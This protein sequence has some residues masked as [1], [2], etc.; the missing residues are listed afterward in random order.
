MHAETPCAE[1]LVSIIIPV[2]NGSLFMKEAIDSALNQTYANCEVIVVND[3]ST[4]EG[5]TAHIARTYGTRIRYFEKPNGGCGSALNV[6]IANMR[7]AYFSW[8]SHDDVYHRSKI[9]SQMSALWRSD[10]R[11]AIVY[12]GYKLIDG[13]SKSVGRVLPERALGHRVEEP[14]LPLLRGLIHGCCLL[15]PR[16]CFEDCGSFDES[17]L[18]TQ[19][20][21][22]WFK[23]L[24]S[25]PL[26]YDPH[27]YVKSRVHPGQDTQSRNDE[28]NKEAN[29]LW[30][31]FLRSLTEDE[32]R[33]VDG[34]RCAFF[35]NMESF[36]RQT[37]YVEAKAMATTEATV[38][39]SEIKVSVVMPVGHCFAQAREAIL[40]V[41]AQTHS[42]WELLIVGVGASTTA[43]KFIRACGEDPRI[44]YIQQGN[45]G[46]GSARNHGLRLATGKYIAFLD[47][48]SMY[49]PE[50][51][52][53]QLRFMEGNGYEVS[54][55]SYRRVTSDGQQSQVVRSGRQGGEIFPEVIKHCMVATPTAMVSRSLLDD[56]CFPSRLTIG[57]DIC[58]WIKL[59]QQYCWRGI[60]KPLTRVRIGSDFASLTPEKKICG[61]INIASF[62]LEDPTLV[63]HT[64]EVGALLRSAVSLNSRRSEPEAVRNARAER[65]RR[66]RPLWQSIVRE[67]I[68]VGKRVRSLGASSR[69][70]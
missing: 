32:M 21:A 12:S 59:A 42:N 8:L 49:E 47:P 34:S 29:N 35:L 6:G 25:Y 22:L 7:G 2:F 36:L 69:R 61:L 68:R 4:D 14:L 10:K 56:R 66:R 54:H 41:K 50:K 55:T 67:A 64:H 24:R 40:S 58:L 3:G 62:C 38:A 17:L 46:Q 28:H 51:L 15:I 31:G 18:F 57:E 26:V 39:L 11:N 13:K 33:R 1:P 20:Y 53:T 44:A 70:G 30:R 37:G 19:D 43:D 16:K 48:D 45:D 60:D 52:D 9:A 63:G 5:K 27:P 65:R 23:F